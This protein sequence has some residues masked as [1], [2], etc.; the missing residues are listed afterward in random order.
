MYK[1]V[2]HK[3]K[4]SYLNNYVCQDSIQDKVLPNEINNIEEQNLKH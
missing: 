4:K 2:T 1:A 3:K